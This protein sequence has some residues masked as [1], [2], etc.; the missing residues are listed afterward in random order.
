MAYNFINEAANISLSQLCKHDST[1][2]YATD[3]TVDGDVDVSGFRPVVDRYASRR[4]AEIHENLL[5]RGGSSK[6]KQGSHPGVGHE[7]TNDL[8]ER[9][10]A[11]EKG[12]KG[13]G[14][15]RWG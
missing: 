7:H 5:L 2:G 4:F 11:P 8:L 15:F 12:G 6:G 10:E 3:F 9:F 1:R 14:G 13:H